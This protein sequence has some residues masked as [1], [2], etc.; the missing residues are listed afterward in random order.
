MAGKEAEGAK[1]SD[2]FDWSEPAATAPSHRILAMRRGEKEG[3]LMVRIQPEETEAV[4]V[5]EK[6]F[7]KPHG[8]AAAGQM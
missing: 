1:Y 2:Y 8:G 5:L 7:V 4:A 6:L 3:F